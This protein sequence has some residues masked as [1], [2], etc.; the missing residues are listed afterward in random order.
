ME[1]L[2][3]GRKGTGGKGYQAVITTP[4]WDELLDGVKLPSEHHLRADGW[5]ST[6]QLAKA[7]GISIR[8]MSEVMQGKVEQGLAESTKGRVG[9][10]HVAVFYR[11]KSQSS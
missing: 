10:G 3:S 7:Y 8:H 1:T 9:T 5:M 6:G 11:P 4:G 2:H